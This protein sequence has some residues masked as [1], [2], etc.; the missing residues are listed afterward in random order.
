MA[1]TTELLEASQTATQGDV[2][3][4]TTQ[5][6]TRR[7]TNASVFTPK[8][9]PSSKPDAS[10]LVMRLYYIAIRAW[11]GS[12]EIWPETIGLKVDRL[13]DALA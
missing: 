8:K 10:A 7:A 13:P 11:F 12:V 3:D 9:M 5:G 1:D 6:M 4:A 2:L